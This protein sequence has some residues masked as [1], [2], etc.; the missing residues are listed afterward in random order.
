MCQEGRCSAATPTPAAQASTNMYAPGGPTASALQ[1][2]TAAIAIRDTVST[3]S[4]EISAA[5][6]PSATA[7]LKHIAITPR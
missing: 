6:L 1:T 5:Q 7:R 2:R 3:P 4:Q